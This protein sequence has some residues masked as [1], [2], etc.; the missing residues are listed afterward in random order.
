MTLV[1][2]LRT[3]RL[4]LEY[5]GTHFVGWQRQAQG[6]SVQ[7]E[8]ERAV[9]ALTQAPARVVAAGRTDAGVHA[10]GQVA[11][12]RTTSSLPLERIVA[13]LN[14]LLP[15]DV[16]VREAAE[17][18]AQFHAR[19]DARF[20]VYRYVIL[21]RPTPSALLHPY[22]YHVR[23]SLDREAMRQALTRLTGAHDFRAFCALGTP[24]GSS[25]CRLLHADLAERGDLLLFTFAADR[26]LRHMVRMMVGTL[27][28]VGRNALSP[29][30]VTRFLASGSG[31]SAGPAAPPQ[32]LYLVY[33][34]Y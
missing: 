20:R 27:L 10:L 13:G 14:A 33:V 34:G 28:R 6:R 31:G 7:A 24:S 17:A 22:A 4:T 30:D 26:F 1:H 19:R 11:H 9:A 25:G 21:C 23:A 18:P 16:A 32:G 15:P 2:P 8:V 29:E 5:D 12:F 3:V